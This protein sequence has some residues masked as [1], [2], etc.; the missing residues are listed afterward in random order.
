MVIG[1]LHK[2]PQGESLRAKLTLKR[3]QNINSLQ[4]YPQP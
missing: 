2:D 1:E 4:Q 3:F